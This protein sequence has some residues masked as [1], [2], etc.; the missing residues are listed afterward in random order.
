MSLQDRYKKLRDFSAAHRLYKKYG[1]K[2]NPFPSSSQTSDNPRLAFTKADES[3]ESQVVSFLSD[4]RSQA[5]VIVG[6]QGV[7]KT[8]FLNYFE[9]EIKSVSDIVPGH[10]VV[11]YMADPEMSFDGILRRLFQELGSDHFRRLSESLVEDS[12]PID[13]ARGEDVR[14]VL[15]RLGSRNMNPDLFDFTMDWLL[16]LRLLKRHRELLGVQ[17][18]LDTVES[19][20]AALRDVVEVSRRTGILSGVFLLLDELEKQDGVLGPRAICALPFLDKGDNRCSS[21]RTVPNDRS[22]AGCLDEVFCCSSCSSRSVG[23]PNTPLSH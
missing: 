15:S 1:L 6:T 7:G 5:V 9:S 23:K 8:N 21:R 11:R 16:G 3:V 13:A 20:T 18:R 10:Y 4:Q 2:G 19:K 14:T 17:F 12:Q 22:D